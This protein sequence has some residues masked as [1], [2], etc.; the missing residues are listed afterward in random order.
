MKKIYTLALAVLA[1]VASVNAQS[2]KLDKNY[3]LKT[4]L[5]VADGTKVDE[6]HKGNEVTA[7]DMAKVQ[8]AFVDADFNTLPLSGGTAEGTN[9]HI[10]KNDYTDAE[11]GVTFPAGT[12]ACLNS[13]TEIKFKDAYN[14]QGIKNI[15]KVIFYLASQGQLQAYARQY[16][17]TATDND[18]CHFEGDPTNRKLNPYYAPGFETETW[19]EMAFNKPLKYVIDLTNSQDGTD[20]EINSATIKMAM[21]GDTEVVNML[22]QFYEKVDNGEGGFVQGETLVPW[23]PESQ[24]VVAFKKKAYVMGVAVICADA[25]AKTVSLDI[26]EANPQ[27][28]ELTGSTGV[29]TAVASKADKTVKAIYT[30]DG[31]RVN[32]LGKG[33]NIVKYSDGTSAKVIR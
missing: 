19:T 12:Y 28:T 33:V 14:P 25:D 11:T 7:E 6:E 26:T 4:S 22:F 13:N 9:Y 27:W 3:V 30:V 18:Y 10:L 5:K 32:A 16:E 31:A 15:K 20:A 2:F 17:G 1:G 29:D 8:E 24:F 21:G 23:T